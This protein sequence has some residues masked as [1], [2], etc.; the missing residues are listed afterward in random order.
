VTL[1]KTTSAITVTGVFNGLSSPAT[2]AHVHGPSTVGSAGPVLF[3]LAVPPDLSGA[4]TGGASMNAGQMAD[5]LN[6]MTYVDIHTN[7]FM[8]GEIRAQVSDAGE[9]R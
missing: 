4:V 3:P 1:N 7:Y 2:G 5:M 9:A 6:R 8:D